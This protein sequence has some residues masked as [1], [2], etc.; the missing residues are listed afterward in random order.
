MTTEA[1]PLDGWLVIDKPAGLSSASA[2][3]IVK[4]ATGARRASH[5][6]T[7]DPL[8]TGILPIA[9][10]EATKTIPFIMDGRK[11]YRF[12]VRWGE[13]RTTDRDE[14]GYYA[15]PV[16]KKAPGKC[17]KWGGMVGSST[18]TSGFEHCG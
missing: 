9:L 7:L 16:K 13:A 4:R 10:G 15:G 11:R 6:G 8:A 2:V 18:Y 5:G 3:A 14:Y 12:T 1:A 17:V